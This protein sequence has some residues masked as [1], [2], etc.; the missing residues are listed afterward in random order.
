MRDDEI[1]VSNCAQLVVIAGGTV[2]NDFEFKFGMAF[3]VSL[4]PRLEVCGEFVVGHDVNRFQIGNAREIVHQPFDNRFAADREQRFRFVQRQRVKA[5][6]VS[7]SE[8]QNVHEI[9]R[10]RSK[11]GK[12]SCFLYG[13]AKPPKIVSFKCC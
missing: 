2:V 3:L 10:V 9:K 12:R 13:F 1:D 7:R 5:S 6:C 11:A 8:N 4:T